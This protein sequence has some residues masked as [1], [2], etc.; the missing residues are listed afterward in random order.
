VADTLWADVSV[1]QRV[2]DDSY[3]HPFFAFRSNDGQDYRD[4][5]FAANRAW[6]DK[7]VASGRM[8]GY[9]VYYVYRPGK[10]SVGLL[11]QMVG[12]PSA[13]MA[14]MCDVENW[15]GQIRGN[16]SEGINSD[17]ARLATWLGNKARVVGYGNVGD[18]N[19]LWPQ[20]PAGIRLVVAAYGSNPAYPGK[21]AHQY[22]D[23]IPCPPF[24]P[25]DGNS[26]DGMSPT[27]VAAMLGLGAV[28]P[29]SPTPPSPPPSPT[30]E[31]LIGSEWY[32]M[33]I[34]QSE[35]DAKQ[36]A[37]L[38]WWAQYLSRTPDIENLARWVNE[39]GARGYAGALNEFL[40]Q[41]EVK[42]RLAKRP[43]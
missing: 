17:I 42:D 39:I 14:V 36:A 7:A 34:F 23:N 5:N 24:G 6:S 29:P 35:A 38:T 31:V 30:G 8:V 15:G 40:A 20:K 41:P 11:Q 43:W 16:Q 4:P 1:Y 28:P 13:H 33:A 3:P 19:G 32:P 10:N 9:L 2:V 27:D 37:V 22:G 12:T 21:F 18:L 25:C 26:A